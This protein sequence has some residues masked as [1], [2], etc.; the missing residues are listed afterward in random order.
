MS[1][2]L[3]GL[4]IPRCVFSV[5]L[6]TQYFICMVP[7]FSPRPNPLGNMFGP[8]TLLSINL[9]YT[10]GMISKVCIYADGKDSFAILVHS[11]LLEPT[12]NIVLILAPL[13]FLNSQ[14]SP[15]AANS[16]LAVLVLYI[17]SIPYLNTIL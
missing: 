9:R 12:S 16:S 1:V 11:P 10:S 2:T 15:V 7:I 14:S 8:N 3:P 4:N 13:S 6:A 17:G 5:S